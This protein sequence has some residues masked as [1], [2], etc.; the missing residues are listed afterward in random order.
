LVA[1]RTS[2]EE[3]TMDSERFDA[4]AR[5]LGSALT[6]RG[7]LGVL[8]GASGLAA[9]AA[10]AKPNR[11]A[12]RRRKRGQRRRPEQVK[13]AERPL[14]RQVA[15]CH[16][17]EETGAVEKLI[18]GSRTAEAAHIR[19]GDTRLPDLD[20]C[21]SDADCANGTVCRNQACGV[22]CDVC[23]IG[24][25]YVRLADAVAD[26]NGPSTIRICAGEYDTNDVL[27]DKNLTVIGMGSEPTDTILR[28][29]NEGARV[30]KVAKDVEV[31]VEHL[32]IR[33]ANL[34]LNEFIESKGG[35]IFNEGTL[36]L[37]RVTVSDNE[38]IT[39][40]GIYNEGTLRLQ[41][42]SVVADNTAIDHCG[43]IM[44]AGPNAPAST[45]DR[46]GTLTLEAGSVVRNNT[47]GFSGAGIF[48]N[49][50]ATLEA[51]SVVRNNTA[52]LAGGGILHAPNAV[53]GTGSLTLKA[54]S[55]V[56]NNVA[57]VGGGL[58]HDNLDQVIATSIEDDTIVSGNT[59]LGC[60]DPCVG[61][62]LCPDGDNCYP[63]NEIPNCIG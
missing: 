47:C 33:G 25:P 45:G 5:A 56:T 15:V 14:L 28:P 1:A 19:H 13:A 42:G 43:G 54:G 29:F 8:V 23:E 35:G 50:V 63:H 51:G 46:V 40:A 26:P 49:G 4:A 10:S 11:G 61:D 7:I 6:R 27:I 31:A 18:V 38:A 48:N 62:C 41:D 37:A 57:N 59:A 24:C 32:W 12:K 60:T 53:D 36:R 34:K 52:T 20:G 39:G 2:A 21:C 9:G 58:F 55:R 30:L 44:N 22:A 3:D 16:V 17:D